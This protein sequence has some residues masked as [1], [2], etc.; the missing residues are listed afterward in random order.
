MKK[1]WVVISLAVA[2]ALLCTGCFPTG[3]RV[4]GDISITNPDQLKDLPDHYRE[5]LNDQILIDADISVPEDGGYNVYKAQLAKPDIIAWRDFCYGDQADE[6]NLVSNEMESNPSPYAQSIYDHEE[7]SVISCAR[8]YT[9]FAKRFIQREYMFCTSFKEYDN[10][11]YLPMS[12]IFGKDTVPNVDRQKALD[13]TKNLVN[14]LKIPV[15]Q[16]PAI[17]AF[18]QDDLNKLSEKYNS[19]ALRYQEKE[20]GY[21]F[22]Y[23]VTLNNVPVYNHD[24]L[25]L[26]NVGIPGSYLGVAYTTYGLDEV[27]TGGFYETTEC[28][29]E[30]V[31]LISLESAF[32]VMEEY[33]GSMV[34]IG[35]ILIN[36]AELCYL[37][38]SKDTYNNDYILQ[39]CWVINTYNFQTDIN[40]DEVDD[41]EDLQIDSDEVEVMT[42]SC[43]PF[44]INAS[45]G[46]MI[47][48][49]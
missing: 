34:E 9:N 26:E 38:V 39:P 8:A 25:T 43:K 32:S 12:S 24:Y 40:W 16:E 22:D 36:R 21:F 47:L 7:G 31:E 15:E 27:W 48:K 42:F 3:A 41:I 20:E 23:R 19:N 33:L 18:D 46:E 10:D 45:T 49:Q 29:E 35:P 1:R 5:K 44:F 28:L 17:Y 6:T 14:T 37:P 11:C 4:D 13:T 2:M 30:N